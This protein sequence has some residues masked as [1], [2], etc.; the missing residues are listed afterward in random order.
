MIGLGHVLAEQKNYAGAREYYQRAI[1]SGD[2]DAAGDAAYKGALLAEQQDY[3]G[4]KSAFQQAADMGDTESMLNLSPLLA[5][6]GDAEAARRL[7]HDAAEAGGSF[8]AGLRGCARR[9]T[10][11]P[12]A[13]PLQAREAR[14]GRRYRRAELPGSARVVPQC[15]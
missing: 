1:D 10:R 12:R 6:E 9:R 2:A 5:V 7:L 4:A 11:Y 8:G 14:R 3:P 15:P 13:D